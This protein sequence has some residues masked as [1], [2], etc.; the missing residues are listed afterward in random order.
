MP[1][2]S[3]YADWDKDALIAHIQKLEK[4]KKYGLV[5]DEERTQEQFE[6]EARDALPVLTEVAD[7]AI[8][9]RPDQPTH[10]LIE[11]DNYH[12]LSVLNYTHERAVDVIYIDPPYNTGNQS[13][14]YN[15]KFVERDDAFKHSKWLSFVSKRLRLA[16]NLL[17]DDGVMIIAIDDYELNPLGLL[18]N[19]IFGEDN[20]LGI[21]V[22][23]NKPS[24]RTTNTF[25]ATSHEYYYFYAKT[26]KAIAIAYW[27]LSNEQKEEYRY[28]DEVSHYKWRDFLRTGGF[29]TPEERPN[30]FYPIYYD[31]SSKK[32]D[33]EHFP[34]SVEILPV[35]T[36]GNRRVWRRTRPS[37]MLAWQKRE[38]Q[39]VQNGDGT[40]KVQ[41]KDRIKSGIKPRTI[42]SSPSYDAATHG[43][44]LLE[45]ILKKPRTF[46]FPKSVYA[47][48]D[49]LDILTRDNQE[50]LIV[51]FFA[52]SGTTAHA[53]ME[54]NR[55][56]G[57]RR[58]CILV[59]NNENNI[60]TEVCYPRVQRVM[61]GYEFTGSE[62]TLLFEEKFTLSGLKKSDEILVEYEQA[63]EENAGQFDELKGEF[64][65]NTL[66][67]WGIKKI[68]GRKDGLG[69]N[70][71]YYRTAFV[72][73][74]PTD[75]NKELL[76]RRSV[77][78][79]CLREDTFDFV[80]E[81]DLWKIYE[82]PAR[83]TG[84]LFDQSAIPEFKEAL[85]ALADDKPISAYVFS[86]GDDNF[87]PEF[88]DLDGRV[89]VRAIP[90]AILRVYRRIFG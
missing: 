33:I 26:P 23:E 29:S 70:L 15:N 62:R 88:A 28:E 73:A 6:A 86:L 43:T 16:K 57:G 1:S 58:Q 41:I 79:L 40:W 78:M 48:K 71:K 22:I 65:D 74:E 35:D 75:A 45:Q 10:I 39:F 63:R 81:T 68:S 69:G 50:A 3:N 5:W 85:R 42:W 4:R 34:N 47:V 53:V 13:W 56:D 67:L 66:R 54:L 49:A 89:S 76:T 59:T 55:E 60:M 18:L 21:V 87:A 8:Q 37:F 19:E 7:K 52:G 25:F 84:I 82:S 46:D 90:E 27:D 20:R 38:I 44:K 9:G 36:K 12:A 64:E 61:Q 72:P 14:K 83:Y 2:K 17:K 80:S 11:G 24:G 51:D 30:S 77:E 31:P 32:A